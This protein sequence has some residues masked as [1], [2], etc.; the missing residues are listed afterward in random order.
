MSQQSLKAYGISA[1]ILNNLC[2]KEL[3]KKLS[4][5][6]PPIKSVGSE[7]KEQKKANA[8]T[9]RVYRSNF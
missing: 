3:I 6:Q 7:T 5:E 2:K 9:K 1:P 4:I 8:R